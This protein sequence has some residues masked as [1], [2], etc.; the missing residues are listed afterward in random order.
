LRGFSFAAGDGGAAQGFDG[1][2]ERVAGLFAENFAE[3]HAK[4]SDVAAKRR[5]LELAGRVLEFGETVRPVGWCPQ[6]RHLSIMPL[7]L[8][9]DW[10]G[11]CD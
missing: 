6:G 1:F 2:V 7:I 8:L 4:R 5:F 11:G 3:E 10:F 9:P